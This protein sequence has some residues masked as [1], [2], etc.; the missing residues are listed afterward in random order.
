MIARNA[1][2]KTNV[3]LLKKKERKK[4]DIKDDLCITCKKYYPN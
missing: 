1:K 4:K 2:K 3:I